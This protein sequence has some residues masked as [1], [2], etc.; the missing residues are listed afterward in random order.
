M[1]I[2]NCYPIAVQPIDN[3]LIWIGIYCS[4]ESFERS[5]AIWRH[6]SNL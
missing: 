6:W 4:L 5:F 3:L 1:L 2:G